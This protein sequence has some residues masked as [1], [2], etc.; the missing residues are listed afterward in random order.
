[1][2]PRSKTEEKKKE[3]LEKF[4]D[5]KTNFTKQIL[6]NRFGNSKEIFQDSEQGW[7]AQDTRGADGLRGTEKRRKAMIA[8]LKTYKNSL[9]DKDYNFEGTSFKD[10]VDLQTKI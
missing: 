10:K 9:N 6:S 4:G 2:T 5:F 8:E 3:D 1:M 7:D